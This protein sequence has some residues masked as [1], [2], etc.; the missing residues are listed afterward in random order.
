MSIFE[1]HQCC[2]TVQNTTI[3][4]CDVVQQFKT[5]RFK[6]VMKPFVYKRNSKIITWIKVEQKVG[7]PKFLIMLKGRPVWHIKD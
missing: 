7:H 3:Q 5:L 6:I 2:S 1:L 4:N